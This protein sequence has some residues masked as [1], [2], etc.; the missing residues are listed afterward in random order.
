[1]WRSLFL[2][3][4]VVAAA[5]DRPYYGESEGYYNGI[6]GRELSA[7][8]EY[9][10]L[11]AWLTKHAVKSPD[12][13]LKAFADDPFYR[14]YLYYPVL[15]SESRSLH[16]AAV[17]P[18]FPRLILHH[19]QSRLLLAL[20]GNPE[21]PTHYAQVEIIELEPVHN[22]FAFHLIDYSQPEPVQDEPASCR[23]CHGQPGRPIWATYRLWTGAYGGF[24]DRIESPVERA[25]WDDF[26]KHSFKQG[27]YALLKGA[28]PRF[29]TPVNLGPRVNDMLNQ[30]VGD[31]NARR[32]AHTLFES[33]AW[34]LYRYAVFSALKSCRDPLSALPEAV[35]TEH[36]KRLGKN[37]DA[38]AKEFERSAHAEFDSRVARYARQFGYAKVEQLDL[39]ANLSDSGIRA[40]F[41]DSVLLF[42][43]LA[44]LQ[45]I[46]DGQTLDSTWRVAN[47]AVSFDRSRPENFS[48]ATT[49]AALLSWLADRYLPPLLRASADP[50]D[51]RIPDMDCQQLREAS[52]SAFSSQ[53][54]LARPAV[55]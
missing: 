37:R 12:E 30:I 55:R 10:E 47:W 9:R 20:S 51:R 13:M 5:G 29:H 46:T 28:P 3:F 44:D 27:R 4:C 32:V 31:L 16:A 6:Y 50:A 48:F 35:R 40:N 23:R 21:F 17:S 34:P 22:R 45:M 24:D 49:E 52:L 19:P 33:P 2:V 43:E 38:L 14:E 54:S 53:T 41:D 26:A 7:R 18:R 36:E 42:N 25:Q 11:K 8:A 15:M 39:L 1:M